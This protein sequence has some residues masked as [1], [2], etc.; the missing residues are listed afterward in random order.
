MTEQE[1]MAGAP[2]GSTHYYLSYKTWVVYYFKI[3]DGRVFMWNDIKK[4]FSDSS[5]SVSLKPL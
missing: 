5:Y 2:D 3:K 4:W 1:I